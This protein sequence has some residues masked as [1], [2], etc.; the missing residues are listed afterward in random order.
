MFILYLGRG[1]ADVHSKTRD[2]NNSALHS[3]KRKSTNVTHK[4]TLRFRISFIH[5]AIG[6]M[7]V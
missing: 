6:Y 4:K 3:A 5:K 2:H 1:K 7:K